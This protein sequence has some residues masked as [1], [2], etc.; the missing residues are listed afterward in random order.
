MHIEA[1]LLYSMPRCQKS[2]LCIYYGHQQQMR[3]F[4]PILGHCKFITKLTPSM[5]RFYRANLYFS[6]NLKFQLACHGF[7]R[8]HVWFRPQDTNSACLFTQSEICFLCSWSNKR[9]AKILVMT[10][11]RFCEQKAQ[12]KEFLFSCSNGCPDRILF[13]WLRSRFILRSSL[14]LNMLI[15][16]MPGGWIDSIS[17]IIVC[18]NV[19]NL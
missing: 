2:Q 19:A 7:R 12:V 17:S 10:C 5:S 14:H 8:F 3:S 13:R 9:W 1:I 11:L 16:S 4:I 15:F 6:F 18:K